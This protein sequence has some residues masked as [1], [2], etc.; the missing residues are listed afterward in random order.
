MVVV[1]QSVRA[2]VCG[3]RGRGFEPHL[4]PKEKTRKLCNAQLFLLL[5]RCGKFIC[6]QQVSNKKG[7]RPSCFFFVGPPAG[8]AERSEATFPCGQGPDHPF[9]FFLCRPPRRARRAQRGNIPLRERVPLLQPCG[10]SV[11]LVSRGKERL[12]HWNSGG[13]AST[14]V[15][16]KSLSYYV[17]TLC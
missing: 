13:E 10:C 14:V 3:T 2:L 8:L 17:L 16:Y 5:T 12:N 15:H 7:Q 1:A 11:A 6:Q 4:P 9:G